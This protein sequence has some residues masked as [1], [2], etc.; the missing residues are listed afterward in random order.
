MYKDAVYYHR[1]E[2]KCGSH[3]QDKCDAIHNKRKMV[4]K[5]VNSIADKLDDLLVITKPNTRNSVTEDEV[6]EMFNYL[7]GELSRVERKVKKGKQ[8]F[9]LTEVTK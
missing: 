4:E 1:D 6:T 9:T 2:S 7:R 3:C 8:P 5:K